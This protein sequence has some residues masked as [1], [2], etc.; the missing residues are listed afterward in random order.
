MSKTDSLHYKLCCKGASFLHSPKGGEV[1]TVDNNGHQFTYMQ[2]AYK[3]IAVELVQ[4]SGELPDVWGFNG[5]DS[6]L[7]EVKTSH[8]D[9]IADQKKWARSENNERKIGNYRYYLCPA[10]VISAGELPDRWGL[11]E[12]DGK[13]ISKTIP[14]QRFEVK[15]RGELLL[16]ASILRREVG[17]SKVFNYRKKE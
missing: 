1:I 11:L 10:G 14:A 15:N 5:W 7:V 6:V 9:F 2:Q 16:L 13:A 8:S 17:P 4:G 12:W 3:Y